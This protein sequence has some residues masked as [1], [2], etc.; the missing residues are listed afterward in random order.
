MEKNTT[1]TYS[2]AWNRW[3]SWCNQKQVNPLSA[4]LSAILEFLKDQFEDG[5]AYRTL[6]VYR[7]ADTVKVGSHPLVSQLLKGVFNLRPPEPKYSCTWDVSRVLDFIKSLGPN[8]ALDLKI[9]S[10]KLV[11]LLGLTAPD[12]S[13]DLAKRDLRFCT[14][15]PKGVSFKQAGLSKTSRPGDLPKISFHAAFPQDK[16]L[17]PVEC[18]RS[19]EISTKEFRPKDST[20][21]DWLFLSFIRPHKAVSSSTL[22]RW[23]KTLLQLAGVDTEMFSAHSLRGAA[24][25][26]SV[27]QGISVP[28]IL[29]MAGWTQERTFSKFY[30]KPLF[31]SSPGK[32][33]LSTSVN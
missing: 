21:P 33:V 9:L 20:Q 16:D 31:N 24:T 7:S 32:A 28:E 4:H 14:F 10:F 27:N 19:Y 8:E 15:H 12:R 18:L 25:S 5:K 1:S 22:A 29:N 6:N 17:C 26:A 23:I 11:M 13:S 30:Y 2:S 3:V